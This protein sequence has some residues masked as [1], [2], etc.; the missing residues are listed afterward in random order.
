MKSTGTNKSRSR[1]RRRKKKIKQYNKRGKVR[2][3][4][5][6]RARMMIK[7]RKRDNNTRGKSI[8]GY[9]NEEA[10]DDENEKNKSKR[11][12]IKDTDKKN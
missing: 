3:V 11:K 8:D 10:M 9:G 7:T 12:E 6:T 4:K 5:R 1:R 2:R